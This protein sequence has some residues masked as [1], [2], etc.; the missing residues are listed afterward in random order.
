M[1]T[2]FGWH[3]L[4]AWTTAAWNLNWTVIASRWTCAIWLKMK[5]GA[6]IHVG[7][8]DV[9]VKLKGMACVQS[10]CL[11]STSAYIH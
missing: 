2:Q 11:C 4:H 10:H 3:V 1:Q 9:E 6:T 8:P 7:L 5:Q